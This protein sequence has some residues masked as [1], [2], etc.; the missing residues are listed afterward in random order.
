V[1]DFDPGVA[2]IARAINELTSDDRELVLALVRRLQGAPAEVVGFA[3][4]V[5][6]MDF[7]E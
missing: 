2:F 3:P 4:D 1:S 7:D 6:F 5:P